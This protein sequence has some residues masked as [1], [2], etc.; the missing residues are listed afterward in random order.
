MDGLFLRVF[1][2]DPVELVLFFLAVFESLLSLF[3]ASC[4]SS[5]FQRK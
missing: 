4:V 1:N 2:Q 5:R 3:A